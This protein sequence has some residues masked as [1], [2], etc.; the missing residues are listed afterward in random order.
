MSIESTPS[1][2]RAGM[3]YDAA[4]ERDLEQ[5]VARFC[6]LLGL[7][8]FMTQF[9]GLDLYRCSDRHG[10]LSEAGTRIARHTARTP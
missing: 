9:L 10:E 2:A 8:C 6:K 5:G 3:I 4:T 7:P 1:A